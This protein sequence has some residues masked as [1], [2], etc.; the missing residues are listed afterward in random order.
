LAIARGI[1]DPAA[2][3]IGALGD[4]GAQRSYAEPAV[5][6]ATRRLLT[7][8]IL[9]TL[10]RPAAPNVADAAARVT[11]IAFDAYFVGKL[12]YEALA[13]VSLVFPLLILMQ[14]M[15]SGGMGGGVSSAIARSLGGG[16]REDANALV[17]HAL[18]IALCMSAGFSAIFLV[19]GPT[20]YAAMGGKG[21]ALQAASTYSAIV[22]SSA[23]CAWLA[24]ILANV[25]RG[26]G[27]MIVSAAA[28]ALG[29]LVHI[30]LSPAMILGL[31]PFP[32]L[33]VAGAALA[34]IASYSVTAMVLLAYLATGRALVR[35]S[36]QALRLQRRLFS[37]ILKVG[38]LSSLNAAQSQLIN[39]VPAGLVGHFGTAALA[40]YGAALRLEII[41]VPIVFSLGAAI[42]AMI[43]ANIGAG[44]RHRAV[45]IAW[46]GAVI[47]AVISGCIGIFGAVFAP[48]WVGL[49]AAEP[50]VQAIG[51][52]YLRIVGPAYAA[53]GVGLTLF[54][55]AQGIGRVLWPF[56]AV[57]SRL[58]IIA[59]GGWV[60]V[61]A[62]G[63]GLTELFVLAAAAVVAFGAAVFVAFKRRV[64]R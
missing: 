28:V 64:V 7:D 16:R 41:Q 52:T 60:V 57:T 40:G 26:T 31:G 2:G 19:G 38:T 48:S 49:F 18:V 13:G 42:V 55:A 58:L 45:Q 63:L 11:F 1:A 61:Y 59:L 6:P 10:L 12:G 50:E 47:G 17:F 20:L 3:V 43:G 53:F 29:E 54:S 56:L 23:V 25:L 9:P 27:N 37:D 32:S 44:Q 30:A 15:A 22:F 8:P 39:V 36:R 4:S 51:T 5:A 46:T 24:N 35:F 21:P 33:G 62:L 34:V 14:T